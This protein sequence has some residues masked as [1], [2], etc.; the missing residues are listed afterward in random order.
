MNDATSIQEA[1][2]SKRAM[3]VAKTY[4]IK[5]V[6][7]MKELGDLAI[8]GVHGC[9]IRTVFEIRSKIWAAGNGTADNK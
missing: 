1:G 8:V 6:G 2:L 9:G 4:D 7:Q 3:K 5:T